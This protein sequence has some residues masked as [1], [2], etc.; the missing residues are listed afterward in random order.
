[1]GKAGEAFERGR[2]NFEE[3]KEKNNVVNI[4]DVYENLGWE[5]A[6]AQYELEELKK[7]IEKISENENE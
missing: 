7:L 1:M 6:R 4:E 3:G 2:K 5:Y